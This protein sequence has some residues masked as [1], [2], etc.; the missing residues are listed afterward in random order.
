MEEVDEASSR[1][2]QARQRLFVLLTN[3]TSSRMSYAIAVCVNV[4]ILSSTCSF[5]Y[6]T[7]PHYRAKRARN[8]WALI[9][10]TVWLNETIC[11]IIFSVE[12]V[13][14]LAVLPRLSYLRHH[15]TIFIDFLALLPWYASLIVGK[16][17]RAISVLRVLRCVR[18]LTMF[19]ATK[20]L[21]EL[22][23]GTVQRAANMLLL[24]V[25]VTT[26]GMCVI[27]G[28]LYAVERGKWDPVRRMFVQTINYSCRIQCLGP[29]EFGIY[30]GCSDASD[31]V[32][33]EVHR[34]CGSVV[35]NCVPN[36]VCLSHLSGLAC[37]YHRGK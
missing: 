26:I 11:S 2:N 4:A 7:I 18:I 33:I 3:Q 24:L 37:G 6:T 5:I 23:G 22:L 13:V 34:D 14:H 36:Q 9:P 15:P 28:A 16:D 32:T 19:R 1:W 12:F 20:Q 17:F 31:Y 21:V 10:L 25:C 35:D 27:G 8:P 29:A 30:D